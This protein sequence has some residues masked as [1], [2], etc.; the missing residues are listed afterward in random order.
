MSGHNKWSSIKHKKAASDAKKGKAFSRI[1][2]ELMLASKTGGKDPDTNVR[3]RSAILAARN[4]NMPKDNIDRAIKKGAGELDGQAL[5]EISY[6]GYAVGGVAVMVDCLTDNRNRTAA[7]VRNIFSKANGTL[8][9]NGAVAWIFD[10]KARFVVQ[11][12]SANEDKLMETCFDGGVDISDITVNE[13]S[14]DIVAPPEEFE[15]L[16]GVLERAGITPTESGIV[17][18]PSNE[19]A[20]TDSS[21]ARQV[22]RLLD[23]LEECDD[24]QNV[25]AN[26]AIND[27]IL[28]E[29]SKT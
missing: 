3:L 5:E 24:V 19:V 17:R 7:E 1:S 9:G 22:L 12:E 6:E 11:G 27:T 23:T 26:A 13:G 20:V 21:V 10:R 4:A 25:Y 14:A 15:K 16:A 8:A 28:G 2:K 29:L 18:V